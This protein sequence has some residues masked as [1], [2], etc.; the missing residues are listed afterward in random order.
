MQAERVNNE[1]NHWTEA[2]GLHLKHAVFCYRDT[3]NQHFVTVQTYTDQTLWSLG[4]V[5]MLLMQSNN[6]VQQLLT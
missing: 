2:D 6:P 1:G 3:Q 5:H 4:K